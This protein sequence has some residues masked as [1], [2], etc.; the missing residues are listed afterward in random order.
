MSTRTSRPA[1]AR[2]AAAPA[3]AS[4]LAELGRQQ[5][6]VA[7]DVSCAMFRGFEAMRRIQQD[8]AHG[9]VERHDAAAKKLRGTSDAADVLAVQSELLVDGLQSAARY[10]Q[11]LAAAAL[12][13]HSEMLGCATRL[14]GS[15]AV[16]ESASAIEGLDKLP[17]FATWIRKATPAQPA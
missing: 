3:P 2:A 11:E 8:A 16:L 9:A 17:G 1:G 12:E 6:A 7:A 13:M 15:Q 10:W 5:A 4:P 14:V